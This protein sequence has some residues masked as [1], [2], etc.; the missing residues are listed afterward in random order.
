MKIRMIET[1][2][3]RSPARPKNGTPGTDPPPAPRSSLALVQRF[4]PRWASIAVVLLIA[5]LFLEAW[6]APDSPDNSS[7]RPG[8]GFSGWGC[9]PGRTYHWYVSHGQ[10]KADARTAVAILHYVLSPLAQ[11]A[12]KQ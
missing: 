3:R 10:W 7:Y 6:F 5:V 8:N 4:G 11:A 12:R 9:P 2:V 1:T